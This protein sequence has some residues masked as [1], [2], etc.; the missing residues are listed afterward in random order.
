MT[1]YGKTSQNAI[2]A[3][4]LMAEVYHE[5]PAVRL[6]SLQIAEKRKLKKP[7]VAK[8]LTVLSQAGLVTGTPGPN[9]GYRLTMA[10]EEI[11][12]FDI[13]IQFDRLE[14]SLSC[15][16]GKDWCG[17]GPQCP[18]HDELNVLRNNTNQF[19]Q[20]NTLAMFQAKN[21]QLI[22]FSSVVPILPL[23]PGTGE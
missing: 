18:L 8:V 22:R 10:P 7:V 9:G 5:T 16:L 12:L 21:N 13:S 23:P 14:E 17:N 1:P 20:K 2:A 11:S 19:L 3:M 15:P 4:S 6:S